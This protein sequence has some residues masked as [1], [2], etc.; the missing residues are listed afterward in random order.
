VPENGAFQHLLDCTRDA[1]KG[2]LF[3]KEGSDGDFVGG[4][5]GDAVISARFCG[6][7][8]EAEAGE[9]FEVRRAEVEVGEGRHVEGEVGGNALGIA[10]RVED[11]QAHVGDGE[12]G[13]DGAVYEFD[14]GV[15]RG[16]RVDG[17]FDLRGL[18][19][20]EAA[21]F[22]DFEALVEHGGGVDGDA[23]AHDPGGVLEGFFYGDGGEFGEGFG[24]EGAARGGEP[25][26]ADF[27]GRAAAHALMDG[28]VFGVDGEERDVLAFGFGDDDFAGSY[29]SFF[30]GEA[31]GFAG[32]DGGVGGF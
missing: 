4:V 26:L 28:V 1:G 8:G 3:L 15:D 11:G 18:E 16:L 27:A 24:A 6:F 10:E 20:E 5:E 17:D 2:N 12:L 30:V 31:N 13:E 25:D 19:V 32:A 29:E 14:E 22:D 9:T 7:I 21:G 23:A